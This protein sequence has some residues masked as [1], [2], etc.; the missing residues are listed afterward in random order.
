MK[1]DDLRQLG[2]QPCAESA[3]QAAGASGSRRGVRPFRRAEGGVLE[4]VDEQA[5]QPARVVE[6]D[7]SGGH[8]DVVLPMAEH[9]RRGLSVPGDAEVPLRSTC[10][11]NEQPARAP[12]LHTTSIHPP[13]LASHWEL[14]PPPAPPRTRQRDRSGAPVLRAKRLQVGQQVVQLVPAGLSA[15]LPLEVI[16]KVLRGLKPPKPPTGGPERQEVRNAIV[17]S[18]SAQGLA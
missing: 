5:D 7:G 16:A 9:D 4:S 10:V 18:D 1:R 14:E 8:T 3:Q 13:G 2:P 6:G 11:G 12:L 17:S 15:V